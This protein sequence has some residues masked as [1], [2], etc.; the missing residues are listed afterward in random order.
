MR[1]PRKNVVHLCRSTRLLKILLGSV[2]RLS[3]GKLP[4]NLL[5]VVKRTNTPL[6]NYQMNG[7]VDKR[8]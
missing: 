7:V 8:P 5:Q 4:V 1:N 3:L 2:M 6:I